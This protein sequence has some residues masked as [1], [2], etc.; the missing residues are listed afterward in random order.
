MHFNPFNA[1]LAK[2]IACDSFD[3]DSKCQVGDLS[4]KHGLINTT[5]FETYYYDPYISLD[6]SHPSFIGGKSLVLHLEDSSKLACAN[7]LP[8][9]NPEDL[10][11]LNPESEAAQVREFVEAAYGDKTKV[12]YFGVEPLKKEPKMT[13]LM[14]TRT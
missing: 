4:G 1:P 7:I 11:L 9:S 5:C 3:N 14:C 13:V 2:D 10:V 6:P 12:L 8:A